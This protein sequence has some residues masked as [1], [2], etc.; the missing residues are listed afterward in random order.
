[1][2][3]KEKILDTAERLFA[4]HGFA[5]T[6]L[7]DITAEADVNLAAVN[8]HFGSKLDL[9]KAVF[10]RRFGPVNAER[11]E[12]L[13]ALVEPDVEEVLRAFFAPLFKRLR[14]PGNGWA[15]FM[16]LVGS[17]H[18][19]TNDEI[20]AC[21]FDEIRVIAIRFTESLAA[22]LPELPPEVFSSR[23]HF[24][25][26]AMAHTFAFCRHEE[27]PLARKLPEADAILENLVDFAVAGMRAPVRNVVTQGS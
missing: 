9:L 4:D 24:V 1:M 8:Y 20:R 17:T 3:T 23:V 21:L 7:R 6:S 16:Q 10:A 14:E 11:L 22:S 15:K 5:S 19:D 26:G 12:R 2:S 13:D 18:S 27:M 25:V